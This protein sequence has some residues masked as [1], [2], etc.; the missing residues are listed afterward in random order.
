MS[1]LM[2]ALFGNAA[3][4]EAKMTRAM[5][6]AI[7]ELTVLQQWLS[8]TPEL[9]GAITWKRWMSLAIALLTT[10]FV[11]ARAV[12]NQTWSSGQVLELPAPK[13]NE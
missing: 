8:D 13:K 12:M 3:R 1:T 11:T 2:S 5:Y 4:R 7:A 6:I 10:G 9:F